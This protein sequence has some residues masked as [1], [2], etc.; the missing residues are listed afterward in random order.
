[1]ANVSHIPV[2]STIVGS[3]E[4]FS[5]GSAASC[6]SLYHLD[7][8]CDH[9]VYLKKVKTLSFIMLIMTTTE[10]S[11]VVNSSDKENL[12]IFFNILFL[13]KISLSLGSILYNCCFQVKW[14]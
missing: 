11:T 5:L 8:N 13:P 6:A 14:L 12:K 9:E 4:N 3:C 7:G 10:V 1:M 2:I